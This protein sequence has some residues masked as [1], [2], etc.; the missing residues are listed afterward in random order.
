MSHAPIYLLRHGETEWNTQRRMQGRLDSPLTSRGQAQARAL[1][2]A[3]GQAL[4]TVSRAHAGLSILSSPQ[5]RA[6]ATARLVADGLGI[7]ADRIATDQRLCEMTWGAMDGHTVPEIEAKWPGQVAARR[8]RHWDYVPPGGESY[9]M[10]RERLR[11]LVAMWREAAAPLV[12]VTHGA[13]GRVVRGLYL[14]LTPAQ[15]VTLDEPQHIAFRLHGGEIKEIVAD[16]GDH[17]ARP[18]ALFSPPSPA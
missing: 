4:G 15:T 9:A 8:A 5:G 18:S 2:L 13:V 16:T 10:L 14:S 3:L 7:A 6:L 1:G 12:V 17:A 11:P